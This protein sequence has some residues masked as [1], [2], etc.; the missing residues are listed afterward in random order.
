MYVPGTLY[1]ELKPETRNSGFQ[2][3]NPKPQTPNH[4]PQTP[5]QRPESLTLAATGAGA[6]EHGVY[7]QDGPGRRAE[8]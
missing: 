8:V 6:A 7:F 3:P 4:K 2:T 1:P 5:N